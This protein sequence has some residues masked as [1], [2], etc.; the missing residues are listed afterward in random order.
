MKE[1]ELYNVDY[2]CILTLY[3]SISNYMISVS[4]ISFNI[5]KHKQE[6]KC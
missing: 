2:F 5:L 1:V 6:F 3:L 4:L